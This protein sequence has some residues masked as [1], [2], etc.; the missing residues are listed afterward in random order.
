MQ[1]GRSSRQPAPAE[2]PRYRFRQ[3]GDEGTCIIAHELTK[4][5]HST[6]AELVRMSEHVSTPLRC[7]MSPTAAAAS[8]MQ[9]GHRIQRASATHELSAGFDA[10]TDSHEMSN[11][12]QSVR[13]GSIEYLYSTLPLCSPTHITSRSFL[14]HREMT[15]DGIY[16][17]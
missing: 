9:T 15:Q 8:A 4:H 3:G 6:P 14:G 2:R 1:P 7:R 17:R 13:R 11:D 16:Q 10:G 12:T 5:G